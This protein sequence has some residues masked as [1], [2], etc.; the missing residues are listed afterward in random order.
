MPRSAAAPAPARPAPAWR[1]GRGGA[2]H[3]G[4][5]EPRKLK[6]GGDEKSH[7]SFV[8]WLVSNRGGAT[9]A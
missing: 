1:P 5:A 8:S 3:V 4:D 2:W 9:R 7:E 6:L